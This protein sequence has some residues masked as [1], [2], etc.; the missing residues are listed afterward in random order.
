MKLP[1][2]IIDIIMLHLP[3]STLDRTR[4]IQSDWVKY[5]TFHESIYT[6]VKCRN[7]KNLMWL[8]KNNYPLDSVM[9]GR[10]IG[11]Y[12]LEL[13]KVLRTHGCPW[14][15]SA[16]ISSLA[17]HRMD[18]FYWLV[19]SGCPFSNKSISYARSLRNRKAVNYLK[20]I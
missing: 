19:D 2:E 7:K 4:E 20:K 9:F 13:L 12:N 5:S 10:A 15:E 3:Y 16:I 11:T 18:I 6:T 17:N 1:Q 14:D 8:L